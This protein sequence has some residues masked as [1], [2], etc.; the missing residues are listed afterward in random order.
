M[1]IMLNRC[2]GRFPLVRLSAET[3]ACFPYL[4]R[5]NYRSDS[6]TNEFAA[7]DDRWRL[8]YRGVNFVIGSFRKIGLRN[9]RYA[10]HGTHQKQT[11]Q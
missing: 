8:I 2:V 5:K 3:A 11:E 7:G 4:S 10:Y 6:G 1:G 9:C